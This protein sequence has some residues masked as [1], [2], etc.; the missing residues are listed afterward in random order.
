[1]YKGN[2]VHWLQN[3]P[4]PLNVSDSDI[5][6]YMQSMWIWLHMLPNSQRF[7]FLSKIKEGDMNRLSHWYK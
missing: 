3:V 4:K 6:D 5:F 7:Q 1:M 2:I